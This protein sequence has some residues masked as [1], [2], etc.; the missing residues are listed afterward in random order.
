MK[1]ETRHKDKKTNFRESKMS[2]RNV[3]TTKKYWSKGA[4]PPNTTN[5]QEL[6]KSDRTVGITE[7]DWSKGINP[8]DNRTKTSC[9]PEDDENV[10]TSSPR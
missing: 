10:A 2:D 6:A 4:I 5:L 8:E 3:G 1:V 9:N 7:R